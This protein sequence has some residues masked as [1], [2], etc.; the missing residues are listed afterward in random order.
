MLN[1]TDPDEMADIPTDIEV[2][3]EID[4]GPISKEEIRSVIIE[5]GVRKAPVEDSIIA[6]LLKAFIRTSHRR[7]R[8]RER[9]RSKNSGE[10]PERKRFENLG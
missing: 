3:E 8:S 4:A 1:R 6:E 5:M 10:R 2:R 9:W 7:G